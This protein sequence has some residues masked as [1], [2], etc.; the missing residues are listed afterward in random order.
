MR[1]PEKIIA[2]L[3]PLVG[4]R[5]YPEEAPETAARPFIVFRLN[6]Q[7]PGRTLDGKIHYYT[8][9]Y[10]IDVWHDQRR[11]VDLLGDQVVE[12][13]RAADLQCQLESSA[14]GADQEVGFEGVSYDYTIISPGP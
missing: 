5:V 11:L 7:Q 2:A 9:S 12:A 10:S 4:G 13:M 14:W 1:T 3:G 6:E 8:D